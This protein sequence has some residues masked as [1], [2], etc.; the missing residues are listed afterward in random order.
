MCVCRRRDR[1]DT[2]KKEALRA[3]AAAAVL[4]SW[5]I[6]WGWR[7]ISGGNVR[8]IFPGTADGKAPRRKPWRK[9]RK[10]EILP[11]GGLSQ[12]RPLLRSG[13]SM[14]IDILN[15]GMHCTGKHFARSEE[16]LRPEMER[17]WKRKLASG[18]RGLP[19]SSVRI[20]RIAGRLRGAYY[21][22]SGIGGAL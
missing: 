5:D 13:S 22:D 15:P 21:S 17:F 8:P 6:P 11:P 14:L 3:F 9:Q 4:L 10:K 20:G 1:R 19:Y 7:S 2:G 12:I 18:A 16:L